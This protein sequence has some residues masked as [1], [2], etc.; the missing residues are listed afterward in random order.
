MC[1]TVWAGKAHR[2]RHP[3]RSEFIQPPHPPPAS[4]NP[5]CFILFGFVCMCVYV[6]TPCVRVCVCTCVC[7]SVCVCVRACARARVHLSCRFVSKLFWHCFHLRL[8]FLSQ[9]PPIIQFQAVSILGQW[10]TFNACKSMRFKRAKSSCGYFLLGQPLALVSLVYDTAGR[11]REKSY[12]D[13]KTRWCTCFHQIL[14]QRGTPW[15]LLCSWIGRLE[16]GCHHQVTI[17]PLFRCCSCLLISTVPNVTSRRSWACRLPSN[18]RA[19]V[20]RAHSHTES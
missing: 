8:I 13:G 6:C 11:R 16:K 19:L 12:C 14:M 17:M 2:N 9:A 15:N 1:G 5:S 20:H 3:P 4:L 10:Q 18:T 7:V